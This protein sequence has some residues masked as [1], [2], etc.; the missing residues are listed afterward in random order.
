M[1]WGASDPAA[2]PAFRHR[3]PARLLQRDGAVDQGRGLGILAALHLDL[4]EGE[5]ELG[6]WRQ[7]ER[8]GISGLGAGAVAAGE[9]SRPLQPVKVAERALRQPAAG[10]E[11]FSRGRLQ[12]RVIGFARELELEDGDIITRIVALRG[13]LGGV[14]RRGCGDII[15]VR[16]RALQRADGG[17]LGLAEVGQSSGRR[18]RLGSRGGGKEEGGSGEGGQ[19]ELHPRH[20]THQPYSLTQARRLKRRSLPPIYHT[21]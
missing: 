8:A 3:L 19:A 21:R 20:R 5:R 17:T 18:C 13:R 6:A 10:D 11:G 15:A 14:Q 1:A 2:I 16:K 4:R 12:R 9:R 7:F